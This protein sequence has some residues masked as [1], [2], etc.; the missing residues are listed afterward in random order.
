M[1]LILVKYKLFYLDIHIHL[2]LSEETRA[3][4]RSLL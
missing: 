2:Q 1:A 4:R 3:N